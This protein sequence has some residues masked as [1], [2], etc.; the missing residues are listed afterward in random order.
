MK[1]T[2]TTISTYIDNHSIILG[3]A[4]FYIAFYSMFWYYWKYDRK[5]IV[6]DLE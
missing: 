4:F 3:I 6:E 1:E 5:Q 2:F